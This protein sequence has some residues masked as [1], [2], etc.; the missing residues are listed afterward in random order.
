METVIVPQPCY[1]GV[2]GTITEREIGSSEARES[3]FS[4]TKPEIGKSV[5][6]LPKKAGAGKLLS[7]AR[8]ITESQ[9]GSE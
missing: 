7:V 1:F 6:T 4:S 5:T 2:F 9:S 3:L 8:R